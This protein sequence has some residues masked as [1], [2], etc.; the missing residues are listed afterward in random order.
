MYKLKFLLHLCSLCSAKHWADSEQNW[1]LEPVIV[2]CR[3]RSRSEHRTHEKRG[4]IGEHRRHEYRG[5]IGTERDR[6]V[7]NTV[8]ISTEAA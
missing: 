3:S 4:A 8:G 7:A 2:L 6:G 5:S 1:Q